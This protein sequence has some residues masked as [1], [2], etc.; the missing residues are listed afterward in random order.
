MKILKVI[1]LSAASMFL[2]GACNAQEVAYCTGPTITMS[3][4]G[5]VESIP[6]IAEVSLNVKSRG[7]DEMTALQGL[8]ENIQKIVGVLTNMNVKDEDM[9]TDS[10]R[11]FPVY[12]QRNRQEILAYEASSQVHYKTYELDKITD[13]MSGVME[14]SKNLFS[15][16]IIQQPTSM[17]LKTKHAQ[18]LLK[19]HAIK[20]SFTQNYQKII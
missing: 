4:N 18:Q 14:G 20:Q 8:S 6:D 5:E 10:I 12:D 7:K 1:S 9:R 3:A 17:H 13:L 16:I 2:V 15:N 11:V 19:K